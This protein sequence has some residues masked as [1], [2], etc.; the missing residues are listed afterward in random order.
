ML[1][2][3]FQS[4]LPVLESIDTQQLLGLTEADSD[5]VNKGE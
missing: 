3:D 4:F 5:L 2:V 1:Q